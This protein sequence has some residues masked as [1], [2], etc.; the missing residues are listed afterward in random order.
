MPAVS[1]RVQVRGKGV[2][3]LGA[4]V[5]EPCLEANMCQNLQAAKGSAMWNGTVDA[6][7]VTLAPPS[8]GPA[9]SPPT[10]PRNCTLLS[11]TLLIST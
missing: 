11:V 5:K 7:K 10:R 8:P 2:R 6:G 9:G 4:T 1:S 3:H